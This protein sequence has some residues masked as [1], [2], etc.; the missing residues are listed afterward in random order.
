MAKKLLRAEIAKHGQ[1]FEGTEF[2]EVPNADLAT[3]LP[4]LG[5]GLDHKWS[6]SVYST[7][8]VIVT[9]GSAT[10]VLADGTWPAWVDAT[11][12]LTIDGTGYNVASRDSDTNITLAAAWAGETAAEGRGRYGAS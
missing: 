1:F 8:T 10:V 9:N 3:E 2:Y 5:P 4:G 12:V 11:S 7:G 6:A